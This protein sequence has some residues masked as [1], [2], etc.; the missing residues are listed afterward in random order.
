MENAD[1]RIAYI[2][3]FRCFG[4]ILMIMG[5]IGFGGMFDTFIHAFHM[6]MFFV[7]SGICYRSYSADTNGRSYI[8]KKAYKLLIPYFCFG[9]GHYVIWLVTNFHYANFLSP[10]WHLAWDN[11][12]GLPYAGALWFLTAFFISQVAYFL[13]DTRLKR[14]TFKHFTIAAVAVM[15]CL[16]DRVLA[17]KLPWALSAAL[18][19]VGLIHIGRIL[20]MLGVTDKFG[21]NFKREIVIVIISAVAVTY[22]IF[23]NG[24]VNMRAGEYRCIPLFWFNAS[25][26]CII[27]I[28]IAW[29]MEKFIEGQKQYRAID[30]YIRL[31]GSE[32]IVYMCLNQIVI[33]V[34]V[35]LS[36]NIARSAQGINKLL[37]HL[38]I[39]AVTLIIL[40][41]VGKM[42]FRY[43][44]LKC[45]IG[46]EYNSS[47]V[48]V[49]VVGCSAVL[50]MTVALSQKRYD[51][52][53]AEKHKLVEK[54]KTITNINSGGGG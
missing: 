29:M 16:A 38:C 34:V 27:G 33:A 30:R 15:G 48:R 25:A 50:C 39:L 28:Y 45:M 21:R 49:I 44:L 35:K 6:P 13:I 12:E 8:L 18:V 37:W 22:L 2:D 42:F 7:C 32:S 14:E 43:S 20:M 41:F 4:I 51:G 23:L 47:I 36:R 1:R 52:Y 54:I 24:C 53:K 11:T 17:F 31:V 9:I 3:Y 5:H 46:A 19:G 40:Y 10:L 26:A